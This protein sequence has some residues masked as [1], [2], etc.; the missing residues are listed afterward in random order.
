MRT[1][2]VAAGGGGVGGD[3]AEVRLE[4]EP[5]EKKHRLVIALLGLV[6]ADGV[7]LELQVVVVAGDLVA[8][9][10][11]TLYVELHAKVQLQEGLPV[12]IQTLWMRRRRRD[13]MGDPRSM[14]I[15]L[16]CV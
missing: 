1:I 9:Q 15:V 2:V 16:T 5:A 14:D 12:G 13:E 8:Q 6:P 10:R 11:R 3:V 4:G 7:R